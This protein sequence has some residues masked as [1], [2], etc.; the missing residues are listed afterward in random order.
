MQKDVNPRRALIRWNHPFLFPMPRRLQHSSLL[1]GGVKSGAVIPLGRNQLKD[2][3]GGQQEKRVL[4]HVRISTKRP[5][6]PKGKAAE[7]SVR[8]RSR[9]TFDQGVVSWYCTCLFLVE[10]KKYEWTKT[11]LSTSIEAH[12]DKN[13]PSWISD[14]SPYKILFLSSA[15]FFSI[16][17]K[18]SLFISCSIV[19]KTRWIVPTMS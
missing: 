6:Q 17:N 2:W 8:Q 3:A 11:Q 13:W 15:T 12:F 18:I 7:V 19:I 9:K 14:P 1:F 5:E 10:N 4:N 16:S